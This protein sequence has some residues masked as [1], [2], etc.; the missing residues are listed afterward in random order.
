MDYT[1]HRKM[2]ARTPFVAFDSFRRWKVR[3][4]K[5]NL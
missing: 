3:T 5:H 2:G 1:S 4:R